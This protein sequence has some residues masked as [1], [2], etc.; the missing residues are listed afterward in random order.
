[1][2]VGT[3]RWLSVSG[4]AAALVAACSGGGVDDGPASSAPRVRVSP[5]VGVETSATAAPRFHHRRDGLVAL[6][7]SHRTSLS[8]A[9]LELAVAGSGA[10][11]FAA[12]ELQRGGVPLSCKRDEA[13]LN[14]AGVAVAPCKSSD[15]TPYAEHHANRADGVEQ[16]WHFPVEPVGTGDLAVAIAVPG[17]KLVRSDERGLVLRGESGAE[18]RYGVAT[19]IDA[20]G[21][22]HRIEPRYEAG[23]ITISVPERIVDES[24]YPAVLDPVIGPETDVRGE[25]AGDVFGRQDNVDI[26]RGNGQYLVVWEDDRFAALSQTFQGIYAARVADDGTLLDPVSIPIEPKSGSRPHAAFDGTNYLVVWATGDGVFA[27]RVTPAGDVLDSQLVVI[28]AYVDALDVVFDGTNYIVAGSP[29]ASSVDYGLATRVTPSGVPLDSPAKQL[30]PNPG[31][32]DFG[33]A[34][35]GTHILVSWQRT[36]LYARRF[37]SALA[38]VDVNPFEIDTSLHHEADDRDSVAVASNGT[39]F[40]VA[41]RERGAHQNDS[42]RVAFRAVGSDGTLAGNEWGVLRSNLNGPAAARN[43]AGYSL[44]WATETSTVHDIEGVVVSA[45][46]VAGSPLVAIGGAATKTDPALAWGGSGLYAAWANWENPVNEMYGARLSSGLVSSD[47]NGVRVAGAVQAQASADVAFNGTHLLVVWEER[48]AEYSSNI[49]GARF[50]THGNVVDPGGFPISQAPDDQTRPRVAAI[51]S[52][53]FVVWEDDRSTNSQH[54][55]GARVSNGGQVLDP[56]GIVIDTAGSNLQAPDVAALGSAALVVWENG[57]IK[58]KRI[59]GG[60][61]VLD[62]TPIAIGAGV[63]PAVVSNGTGYLTA[64]AA[65]GGIQ[66]VRVGGDGS[67]VDATP[68][69]VSAT[70]A[71]EW[72]PAAASDGDGYFIVWSAGQDDARGARVSADG[73]V[74]D[75]LGIDL[76]PID[77]T[78]GFS[79][80]AAAWNG[81]EYQVAWRR[82]IAG[83]DQL[84]GN[85]VRSDS[86][87][88]DGAS[89]E[90]SAE[91]W[92]EMYPQLAGFGQQRTLLVYE[93][94]DPEQPF[95][96]R[97]VRARWIAESPIGTGG[98]GGSAG[99]AGGS[100]TGGAAGA[101]TGGTG[102]AGTGGSGTGGASGAGPVAPVVR[103][104]A[105]AALRR[106]EAAAQLVAGRVAPVRVVPAELVRPRVPAAVAQPP[107]VAAAA[108]QARACRGSRLHARVRAV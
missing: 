53:F 37:T 70:S 52:D 86:T 64:F 38:P 15:G 7:R 57:G 50:D 51:G 90:L 46:G 49:Y 47:G 105:E 79:E 62:A 85:R 25:M 55:Y 10:V 68:F 45:G 103:A 91:P 93:R 108:A 102:G 30:W 26:A 17:A 3:L 96:A 20:R 54:V 99:A 100:S 81:S 92:A 83:A 95:G 58:G 56:G 80:P 78:N 1:M 27:T 28:S 24:A 42:D 60:G 12:P 5:S 75:P 44:L 72:A 14:D 36:D 107:R 67:V 98:T 89:I 59:D 11:T 4:C 94:D 39:E 63:Q 19:W 13:A 88:L 35:N 97:R 87:V 9:G 101:S 76:G 43:G 74:L 48:V 22:T 40:L 82:R 61:T 66:A 29:A 8:R 106:G 84:Y 2:G 34:W 41:W 16:S 32:T 65:G 6:G 104:P 69:V 71:T 21:T 77:L 31:V 23:S 73:T 18:V 33:M